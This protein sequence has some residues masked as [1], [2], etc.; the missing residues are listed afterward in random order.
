MAS[1]EEKTSN[2]IELMTSY[3][4]RDIYTPFSTTSVWNGGMV[5]YGRNNNSHNAHINRAA[6]GAAGGGGGEGGGTGA[7]E[8]DDGT[9]EEEDIVID[10]LGVDVDACD[11]DDGAVAV[12]GTVGGPFRS[13]SGRGTSIN[14]QLEID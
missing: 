5:K 11:D 7:L 1:S 8:L 4:A 9:D 12:A 6:I 14:T 10:E 2:R 3:H 13:S